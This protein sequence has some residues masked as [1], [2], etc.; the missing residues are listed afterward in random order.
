ML[1]NKK[2][3]TITFENKVSLP[4]AASYK[5]FLKIPHISKNT[6]VQTNTPRSIDFGFNNV[7]NMG[8]SDSPKLN[9]RFVYDSKQFKNYHVY[10][11]FKKK[12]LDV[13]Y[14]EL[15][16]FIVFLQK[17]LKKKK[18]VPFYFLK[19]IKGGFMLSFL[20][21]ICFVPRSLFKNSI[22]QQ[23]LN[24]K[25]YKKKSKKFTKPSFKVNLISSLK[26]RKEKIN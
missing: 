10:K 20:G 13:P 22:K 4:T 12:Q 3:K 14:M 24:L 6:F 5:S 11:N 25:I 16:T 2:I 15:K 23:L 1:N 26:I 9:T 21:I 8:L 19:Q 7:F 18:K 17:V